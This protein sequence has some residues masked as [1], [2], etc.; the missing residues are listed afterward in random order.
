[1]HAKSRER[2]LR[3]G[4]SFVRKAQPGSSHRNGMLGRQAVFRFLLAFSDK[5]NGFAEGLKLPPTP[6]ATFLPSSLGT[7]KEREERRL[8]VKGGS[9]GSGCDAISRLPPEIL[10]RRQ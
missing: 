4:E 5:P 3:K 9:R 2:E 8:R 7:K 1:M 6:L 10:M